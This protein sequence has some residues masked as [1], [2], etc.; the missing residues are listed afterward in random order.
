MKLEGYRQT[1]HVED[2]ASLEAALSLRDERGGADLWLSPD[3]AEYACL[4]IRI[5]GNVGDVHFL[6]EFDNPGYRCLGGSELPKNGI[7]KLVFMGCDP[8]DGEEVPNEFVVPSATIVR[9]A[10]GF[11]LGEQVLDLAKWLQL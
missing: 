7:T 4:A 9:V 11:L 2:A 5:G 3:G 10:R 8:G 6:P 1:W